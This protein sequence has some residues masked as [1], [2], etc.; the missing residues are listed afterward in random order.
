MQWVCAICGYIHDDEE[1]PDFCP[2]CGAPG[3]H[4]SEWTDDDEAL[5][6]D[7]DYDDEDSDF[8]DDND[9]VHVDKDD[10]DDDV[11]EIDEGS[12]YDGYAEEFDDLEDN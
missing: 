1:P 7:D 4:F 6:R 10:F 9:D 8:D 3:N 11:D 5:V 2:D 12:V